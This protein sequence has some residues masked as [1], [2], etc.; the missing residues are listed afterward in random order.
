MSDKAEVITRGEFD[1]FSKRISSSIDSISRS[2][3]RMEVV[4]ENMGKSV[5]KITN[6]MFGDKNNGDGIIVKMAR[7][8]TVQKLQ[9]WIG[10]L[11]V[12][13][14]IGFAFFLMQNEVKSTKTMQQSQ[15][16][17]LQGAHTP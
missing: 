15:V 2:V 16:K 4:V 1:G 9:V 17:Q 7:L 10:S 11:I 14:I 13:G 3:N 5:D 8:S 12:A 6:V